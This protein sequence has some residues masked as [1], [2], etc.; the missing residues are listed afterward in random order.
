[1]RK[2]KNWRKTGS[3]REASAGPT[4]NPMPLDPPT[5]HCV[6]CM[7]ESSEHWA[8]TPSSRILPLCIFLGPAF[9]ICS[10]PEPPPAQPGPL[11]LSV[12]PSLHGT[13]VSLSLCAH[14]APT[15]MLTG[16]ELRSEHLSAT[17]SGSPQAL[18]DSLGSPKATRFSQY[19]D[20]HSLQLPVTKPELPL[21]PSI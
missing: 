12:P 13:C 2:A 6:P 3:I 20:L 18:N 15:A 8:A 7:A 9:S 14:T 11:H 4:P 17:V 16:P 10:T 1:M 19:K 5:R 21:T